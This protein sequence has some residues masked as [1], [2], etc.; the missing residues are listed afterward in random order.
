MKSFI[1]FLTFCALSM[2]YASAYTET[3]E[4]VFSSFEDTTQNTAED[5]V[6][7]AFT[8]EPVEP[9]PATNKKAPSSVPSTQLD[10]IDL[11]E[12][13]QEPEC[14]SNTVNTEGQCYKR[15]EG[16]I[17]LAHGGYCQTYV[18]YTCN[19]FFVCG[20]Q[21]YQVCDNPDNYNNYGYVCRNGAY[22][23]IKPDGNYVGTPCGCFNLYGGLLFYGTIQV[24]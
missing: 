16:D 15:D 13:D 19:I 1:C 22:H 7:E 8:V 6:E 20:Y 10:D 4:V 5:S 11:E 12:V 21:T 18:E 14:T 3:E 9:L 2:V 17:Q 23:C 24:H